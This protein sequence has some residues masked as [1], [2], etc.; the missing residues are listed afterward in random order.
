MV[1]P[2]ASEWAS[3]VQQALRCLLVDFEDVKDEE[4]ASL[5]V[6]CSE[7]ALELPLQ[8]IAVWIAA[9]VMDGYG[10]K[11][12][13]AIGTMVCLMLLEAQVEGLPTMDQ[14]EGSLIGLRKLCGSPHN[15]DL[16]RA[17]AVIALV[18]KVAAAAIRLEIVDS[19]AIERM[20]HH[21]K[22][23]FTGT[24]V[25]DMTVLKEQFHV[26]RVQLEM[27][28][29]SDFR[30]RSPHECTPGGELWASHSPHMVSV[31]SSPRKHTQT[32]KIR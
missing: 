22:G 25:S 28:A 13:Y 31:G 6:Q 21:L 11:L 4:I 3:L 17:S 16:L 32:S 10:A 18:E 19:T 12:F 5:A 1:W 7:V 14:F 26:T 30:T 29:Q 27:L 8:S 15:V 20:A 2:E 23:A 9:F 24:D